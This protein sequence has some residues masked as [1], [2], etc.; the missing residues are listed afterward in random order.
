MFDKG[1]PHSVIEMKRSGPMSSL[2][3]EFDNFL[4]AP[5]G[6]D[7]NGMVLSVLSA[8]ARLDVDPWEEAATLARLPGNTATRKLALLIAALLDGPSAR[9][10]CG[11]IAA[12]LISLLPRRVGSDVPSSL[13]LPGIGPVT[14]SPVVRYLIV[15]VIFTF[16]M[17]ACQWL[18]GGPQAPA[19]V[20]SAATC[21]PAASL[22]RRL[23]RAP[24]SDHP[25]L[26]NG[27]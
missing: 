27:R 12:R 21:P 26:D 11:T 6:E 23:H 20:N 9:P 1:P 17:L 3:S 18:L 16:F 10:N 19:Q 22:H 4:L 25:G 14:K 24:G 15:Y 5:I 13:T 7:N 2:G 8:L